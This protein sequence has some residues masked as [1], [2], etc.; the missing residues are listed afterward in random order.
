MKIAL[1]HSHFDAAH[2]AGV[3]A[4][5]ATL[6]APII[7]AVWIDAHGHWA[8]LE[9]AHRI[10]AAADLGLPPVIQKI[11]Y[12]EDVTL[13]DLGCDDAGEGYTVAGVADGSHRSTIITFE[14]EE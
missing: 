11:E 12:S 2:L 6:G 10:R 4:E 5:M 8:A 13:A 9:G 1:M 7:K 14:A 3:K